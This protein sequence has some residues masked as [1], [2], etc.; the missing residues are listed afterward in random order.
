MASKGLDLKIFRLVN[1]K[2]HDDEEEQNDNCTR[3]HNDLYGSQKLGTLS[4]E[5][6]SNSKQ[7]KHE[8]ESGMYWVLAKDH[9]Q[10]SDQHHDRCAYKYEEFHLVV[11]LFRCAHAI[12]KL[13][14]PTNNSLK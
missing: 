9:A 14:T 11:T 5:Q 10:R 12:T 1:T 13:A 8:A 7:R 4:N 3:V 6:N 2:Q